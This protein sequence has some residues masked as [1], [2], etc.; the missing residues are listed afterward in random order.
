MINMQIESDAHKE[1]VVME[2][3]FDLLKV[4]WMEHHEFINCWKSNVETVKGLEKHIQEVIG[5]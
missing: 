5:D 3:N 2:E 1:L 4:K